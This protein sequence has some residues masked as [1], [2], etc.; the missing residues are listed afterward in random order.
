MRNARALTIWVQYRDAL[1]HLRKI[2]NFGMLHGDIR[3]QNLIV[4]STDT[5]EV[6]WID[7][8]TQDPGKSGGFYELAE[9][10]EIFQRLFPCCCEDEDFVALYDS[11]ASGDGLRPQFV[12][13]WPDAV[14][15]D[16]AAANLRLTQYLLTKVALDV[17][18][19]RP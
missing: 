1:D 4:K 5:S 18:S 11:S 8:F 14:F 6:V 13:Q 19:T 2:H 17:L 10:F 7:L 3:S 12:V 9:V 15:D 16:G